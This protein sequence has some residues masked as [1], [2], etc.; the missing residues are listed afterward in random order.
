MDNLIQAM[1]GLGAALLIFAMIPAM[2]LIHGFIKDM[3]LRLVT[4]SEDKAEAGTFLI[5]LGGGGSALLITARL[6][7]I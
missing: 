3:L 2:I 6:L 4:Y 5:M 7:T 1:I